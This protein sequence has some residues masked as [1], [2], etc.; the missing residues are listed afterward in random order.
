MNFKKIFLILL[1]AQGCDKKNVTNVNDYTKVQDVQVVEEDNTGVRIGSQHAP[2][3]IVAYTSLTCKHCCNFYLNSLPKIKSRY[4]DS[5]HASILLKQ[6]VDDKGS[7]EG[8]VLCNCLLDKDKF[9]TFVNNLYKR[10]DKWLKSSNPS[11]YLRHFTK[12]Y[13]YS[14]DNIDD[15]LSD[16][17]WHK[18]LLSNQKMLVS[19]YDI[20]AVPI[21]IVNGKVYKNILTS[22]GLEKVINHE[23]ALKNPAA[24][25]K[26]GKNY[27][28]KR[29]K[30]RAR[31]M[32]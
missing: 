16:K 18:T 20:Q 15:C 22:E 32:H 3:Q 23:L 8:S 10:Q 28:R 9:F 5:G 31:R 7:L 1:F 24:L 21:F 6:F 19:V 25:K 30:R 11:E 29:S 27:S 17:S 4:I 14:D 2:V 12:F 26:R 13:G